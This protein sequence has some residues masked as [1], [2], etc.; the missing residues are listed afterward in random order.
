VFVFAD[1][2]DPLYRNRLLAKICSGNGAG[3]G[4]DR[5]RIAADEYRLMDDLGRV[6]A[7]SD[8]QSAGQ[9]S[10]RENFIGI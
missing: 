8:S 3:H 2:V 4:R 10:H 9:R 6:K 5:I 1:G 7:L